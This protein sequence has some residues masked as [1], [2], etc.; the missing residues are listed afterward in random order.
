MKLSHI[1]DTS[2]DNPPPP[3][4]PT[5]LFTV[6]C[7]VRWWKIKLWFVQTE[8][9]FISQSV[10]KIQF[11][12]MEDIVFNV[13][14]SFHFQY[15]F[16]YLWRDN[17]KT[18]SVCCLF[19]SLL[20]ASEFLIY[21]YARRWTEAL[22]ETLNVEPISLNTVQYF[23]L[24]PS[25]LR[26]HSTSSASSSSRCTDGISSSVLLHCRVHIIIMKITFQTGGGGVLLSTRVDQRGGVS[27][28]RVRGAG[29]VTGLFIE[30]SLISP[31]DI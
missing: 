29:E 8:N 24:T 20:L 18:V 17:R 16:Q 27:G 4:P 15:L 22:W 30:T 19:R 25:D 6:T 2:T 14:I 28:L 1:T 3:P 23:C 9:F 10:T 21:I 5:F 26:S 12:I 13:Y 7:W 11:I 31:S